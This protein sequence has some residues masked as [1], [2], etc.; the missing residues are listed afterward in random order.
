[1]RGRIY[2]KKIKKIAEQW[3]ARGKSYKEI[4]DLLNIPK[5]TLS[6]W[7][8]K[9]FPGIF[10]KKKQLIHLARIRPLA[11]EAK[12][13]KI[14]QKQIILREKISQEI[15]TYPLNNI[16]LLKSILSALYW[17]EGAKYKGVSGLKFVNTDPILLNFYISLLRKC[18]KIN[19]TKFRIRLHL[20]Y[21][22]NI[23]NTKKFWSDLLDVPLNQ[24]TSVYIKKRS[25]KKRFRKN[26]MGICFIN[27]LN[28]GIRKEL[29][30]LNNQLQKIITKK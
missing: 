24:F 29:M 2:T 28:S 23:R 27:Y 9:K 19:E 17:A 12:N 18:Y 22:H 16:G 7:F 3:R 6:T 10:D 11:I 14:E 15:K 1:M 21:Y 13:R 20:H 5:S 25:K 30:E 8:G 4:K 26:F